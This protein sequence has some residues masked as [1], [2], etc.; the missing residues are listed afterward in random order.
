M[1]R[2]TL[3]AVVALAT[4]TYPLVASHTASAADPV[5]WGHR[6]GDYTA[7]NHGTWTPDWV[8]PTGY[9]VQAHGLPAGWAWWSVTVFDTNGNSHTDLT[10]TSGDVISFPDQRP[11]ASVTVCKAEQGA[12]PSSTSPGTT[13]PLA[14]S[15]T[16]TLPPSAPTSSSPS[17][18]SPAMSVPSSTTPDSE[19]TTT[20]SQP[21]EPKPST[22]IATSGTAPVPPDPCAPGDQVIVDTAVICGDPLPVGTPGNYGPC[23]DADGDGFDDDLL[24]PCNV[25]LPNDCVPNSSGVGNHRRWTLDPCELP[26]TTLNTPVTLELPHTGTGTTIAWVAL[27]ACLAG[28]GALLA[29]RRPTRSNP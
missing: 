19:I 3:L 12:T 1:T 2:K 7:G 5:C 29:A 26:T 23:V 8:N 17:T 27:V 16:S 25:A 6:H 18:S 24:T 28:I 22:T 9:Q 4:A 13:P 21:P 11:L 20:S 14:P 10:V 15:T